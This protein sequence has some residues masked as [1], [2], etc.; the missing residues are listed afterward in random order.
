MMDQNVNA[1]HQGKYKELK[2]TFFYEKLGLGLAKHNVVSMF[3]A[4]ARAAL[5][6]SNI[7]AGWKHVGMLPFCPPKIETK[8]SLSLRKN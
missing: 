3:V 7:I 1:S 2:E 4:A 8:A 5:N 6:E